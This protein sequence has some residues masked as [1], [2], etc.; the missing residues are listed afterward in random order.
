M[1]AF[2]QSLGAAKA[3]QQ[4][5]REQNPVQ[6]VGL[7]DEIKK[8]GKKVYGGFKKQISTVAKGVK[9]AVNLVKKIQP[10]YFI[11]FA[12]NSFVG[13]SWDMPEQVMDVNTLGVL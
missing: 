3:I 10:D 1:V 2:G 6:V 13:C 11:N 8:V 12:A 7:L 5:K 4:Q 9:K